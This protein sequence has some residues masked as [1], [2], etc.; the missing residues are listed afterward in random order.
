MCHPRH[1][2]QAMRS[3]MQRSILFLLC[4]VLMFFGSGPARAQGTPGIGLNHL[5]R[6]RMPIMPAQGR[7]AVPA[8]RLRNRLMTGTLRA[9]VRVF[10]GTFFG[11]PRGYLASVL[12]ADLAYRNTALSGIAR[13]PYLGYMSPYYGGYTGYMMPYYGG[14]S[15]PGYM[16]PSYGGYSSAGYG[17]PNYG[18]HS[19]PG[20]TADSSY[21]SPGAPP[22]SS[23]SNPNIASQAP[24]APSSAAGGGATPQGKGASKANQEQ[25]ATSAE[26]SKLLTAIGLPNDKGTLFYPLGLRVLQ[27]QTENMELLDRIETLLKATASQEVSGKVNANLLQEASGA[28][29][30]LQQLLQKRQYN[31]M[32]D[33][34][35]QA[36]QYLDK[37]RHALKV[38]QPTPPAPA[39]N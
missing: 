32:P 18:G 38:L 10:P 28:V 20:Y 22:A 11:L 9:P 31:M 19:N 33:T 7:A 34:Y 2:E 3:I 13:W 27:P 25:A 15:N 39:A 35:A 36:G 17:M 5:A 24:Y 21:S 30:R 29:D 1:E 16:M 6:Q 8:P 14:Y 37:L 23:Y 26:T 4:P 12:A